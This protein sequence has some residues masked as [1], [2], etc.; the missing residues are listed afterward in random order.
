DAIIYSSTTANYHN[1]ASHIKHMLW[2]RKWEK[3]FLP[4]RIELIKNKISGLPES[5]VVKLAK[6][7]RGLA[8]DDFDAAVE[9]YKTHKVLPD[10]SI[11]HTNTVET[12]S[13]V[14]FEHLLLFKTYRK[15]IS[16]SKYDVIFEPGFW[17]THNMSK[18]KNVLGTVLN[19]FVKLAGSNGIRLAPFIYVV[20]LP[21]H[22]KL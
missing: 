16:A 20:A 14:W 11:H 13:G 22:R 17:D 21:K 7:T 2:H 18:V 4:Q 19:P 15:L 9:N 3:F 10:P 1:P 12:S 8:L 5:E 6:A